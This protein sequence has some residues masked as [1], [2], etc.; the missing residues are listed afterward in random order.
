[1][2]AAT[3]L[4]LLFIPMLYVVVRMIVPR[5]RGRDEVVA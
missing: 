3:S 1:M 2:I 5:K 4:N